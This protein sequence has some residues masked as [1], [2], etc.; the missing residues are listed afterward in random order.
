MQSLTKAS[1][2]VDNILAELAQVAGE[3][4]KAVQ[5]LEADLTNLE[6]QEKH[7]QKRI[8]DLQE[9]PIPVAEH[10]AAM[11]ARGERRSAWRDYI[12]F[13]SGVVVSTVI[14]I[15]LRLAGLA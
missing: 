8:Q 12:L 11:V 1:S 10:F 3:R 13:A 15:A 7:L 14:A 9:V 4:A 6:E 2:E 5:Q